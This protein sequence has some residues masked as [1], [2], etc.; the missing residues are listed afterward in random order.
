MNETGENSVNVS[1]AQEAAADGHPIRRV[2]LGA[3]ADLF[4]SRDSLL[5]KIYGR[6]PDIAPAGTSPPTTL[7]EA[8]A[9]ADSLWGQAFTEM[10]RDLAEARMVR[11]T[12][13]LAAWLAFWSTVV[14]LIVIAAFVVWRLRRI[15][16]GDWTDYAVVAVC[17]VILLPLL[18]IL[19]LLLQAPLMRPLVA[20]LTPNPVRTAAAG[21]DGPDESSTAT[22]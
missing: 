20:V 17:S 12:R 18:A 2:I 11:V 10:D 15:Q 16:G 21:G 1:Q 19:S 22:D 14:P 7:E 4:R 5:L 13:I 3:W 8:R 9:R 6:L